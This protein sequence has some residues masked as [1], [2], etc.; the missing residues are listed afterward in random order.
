MHAQRLCVVAVFAGALAVAGCE[1]SDGIGSMSRGQTMGSAGG[2]IVGGLAGYAI[3]GGA[4]GTL[5]GAAA[6]GVI[7]NRLGNFLE[8]DADQAAAVAAARAAESGERV[9][10]RKTGATFL[11]T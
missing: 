11:T 9:T 6:G 1:G 4:V 2:A 5:I 7:E 8:G 10:W 3:S